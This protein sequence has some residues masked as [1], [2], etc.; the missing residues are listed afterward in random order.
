[1]MRSI[2]I[3]G[4]LA[5]SLVS[6]ARAD[7]Y[8]GGMYSA[9][10]PSPIASDTVIWEEKTYLEKKY[11]DIDNRIFVATWLIGT[12]PVLHKT[13]GTLGADPGNDPAPV[14]SVVDPAPEPASGLLAG[15]GLLVLCAVFVTRK[16]R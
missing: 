2:A 16:R 14:E 9:G 3:T 15:L 4:A 12:P 5:L 8:N 6:Q 7:L 13:A 1:M 11:L 10:Q